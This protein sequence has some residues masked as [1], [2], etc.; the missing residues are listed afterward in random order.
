MAIDKT[1]PQI[2]R[3]K[4]M[5]IGFAL[6]GCNYQEAILPITTIE[7]SAFKPRAFKR[8]FLLNLVPTTRPY[9]ILSLLVTRKSTW[10]RLTIIS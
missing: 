5:N 9:S 4:T 6:I 3:H 1:R 10:E 2:F 8:P 7:F